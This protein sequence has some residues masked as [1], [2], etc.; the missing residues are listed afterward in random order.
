MIEK[1]GKKNKRRK[2]RYRD[3]VLKLDGYCCVNCGGRDIDNPHH[4][5]HRS[6]G[7]PDEPHNRIT[8]CRTCHKKV[9]GTIRVDGQT[10]SEY[11]MTILDKKKCTPAFR[12]DWAYYE[13]DKKISIKEVAVI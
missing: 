10:G 6:Q 4:I 2:D 5:I 3:I 11:M 8:L 12:W 7:G 9:H 13:L 1:P